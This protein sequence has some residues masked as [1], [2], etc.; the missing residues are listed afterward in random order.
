MCQTMLS[1]SKKQ[2][3][4]LLAHMITLSLGIYWQ[5]IWT[6]D[7]LILLTH[8]HTKAL[9]FQGATDKV[10]LLVTCIAGARI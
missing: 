4:G 6:T 8:S 2:I 3:S 10:A 1:M 7:I 5:A 9:S